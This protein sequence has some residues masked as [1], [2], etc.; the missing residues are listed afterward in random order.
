MRTLLISVLGGLSMAVY[1]QNEWKIDKDKE[2][3]I[4]YTKAQE[5]SDFKSFKAVMTVHASTDKIVEILKN[6]D[7]YSHG[8]AIQKH[9]NS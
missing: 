7:D 5:D 2:G 9:R 6:A 3:I 1:A 8:M 4:V